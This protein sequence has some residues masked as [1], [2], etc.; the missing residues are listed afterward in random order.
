M[1]PDEDKSDSNKRET[2][3]P[4]LKGGICGVITYATGLTAYRIATD[5][6]P[7]NDWLTRR[8]IRADS[9]M[10]GLQDDNVQVERLRAFN[11]TM[12][13]YYEAVNEVQDAS[14]TD[15]ELSK[16]ERTVDSLSASK[17]VPSKMRSSL[18]QAKQNLQ[19][20]AYKP[21]PERAHFYN[22][23]HAAVKETA[24]SYRDS[25]QQE[26][27]ADNHA[28]QMIVLGSTLIAFSA[29][30]GLG[31]WAAPHVVNTYKSVR[32]TVKSWYQQEQ[33]E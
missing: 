23:A 14:V 4:R 27:A 19:V 21:A 10:L 12:E 24:T 9:E 18:S 29:V 11:K 32:S 33:I 31:A 15:V 1:R 28:E 2:H 30:A 22:D 25:L 5:S 26:F 8:T 6:T 16:L 17:S 13:P 3:L 7:L 20:F